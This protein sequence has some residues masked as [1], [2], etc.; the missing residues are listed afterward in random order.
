MKKLP[1]IFL[2]LL[3]CVLQVQGQGKILLG[4]YYQNLPAFSP[5][6]TGANDFLDIRTGFRKQW[7]GFD[8]APKTI[9]ASAYS[10][11]R[12]KHNAYKP[13][14]LRASSNTPYQAND[15]LIP[16]AKVGVGGYV[17]LDERGPIKDLESML[18]VAVHVPITRK[19]Y[20]SLGMSAGLLNKRIDFSDI[21]VVDAI[22]DPTYLN[23]INNG[24]SNSTFNLNTSIGIHSHGYYFSYSA[25]QIAQS[26]LSGNE[27]ISED[28]AQ[29]IR[30]HLMGGY[31]FFLDSKWELIPNT[32]VRIQSGLPVF[33]E[34]G[35]RARYN[36]NLWLG[37][38]Y[39]NDKSTVG[40]LGF[41]FSDKFNFGYAYE[42]KSTE[43][44]GFNK[45]S[46]EITL[47]I[48]LFNH[49]NYASIW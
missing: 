23:Y 3:A 18:S 7:A 34:A 14:S 46:H 30:H 49:S 35:M 40:M 6:F 4:Q 33:Y 27:N 44:S 13:N 31:R 32:F 25:M 19:T 16:G 5:S 17:L 48:R 24:A 37:V 43:Y 12:F 15:R 9:F 26:F 28:E 1:I 41:N 11:I 8:N 36:Q 29:G 2:M 39:R 45:G 10:P 38:S 22:N 20:L 47:G 21:T 42:Y